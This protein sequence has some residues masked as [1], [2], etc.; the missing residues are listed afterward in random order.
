M[1]YSIACT[2]LSLNLGLRL[3]RDSS[4]KMSSYCLSRYPTISEKL[5]VGNISDAEAVS[6]SSPAY[7]A[8]LSIW[9]PNPGVSTMVKEIRVPSS[10]SSSSEVVLVSVRQVST[11]IHT[12]S[13]GLN[14]DTI[15]NMG[16]ASIIRVFVS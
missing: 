5:R 15:L 16:G 9:S 14:L 11:D 1:K 6:T 2:R 7:L 3:I 13:D 12:N 4:A 8:S 10:S